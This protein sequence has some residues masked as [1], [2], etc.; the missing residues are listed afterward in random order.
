MK[1]IRYIAAAVIMALG[2]CCSALP[3]TAAKKDSSSDDNDACSVMNQ[4]DPN[5]SILCGH[6]KPDDSAEKRIKRIL[7]NVY[8]YA[9]ILAV[10]VIIIGGIFYATS[11]GDPGK[12]K[13]AKETI[14]YASIGLIVVLLAFA[15]TEFIINATQGNV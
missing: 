13:R 1:K 12:T 3:T 14:M 11:M 6:K 7:E 10:V 2:F 9:G 5:Y 15:I 4:S 8:F